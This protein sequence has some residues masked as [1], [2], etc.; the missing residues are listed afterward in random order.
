M[1]TTESNTALYNS[2]TNP[3][4]KI[5]IPASEDDSTIKLQL[6]TAL[7][8]FP[9]TMTVYRMITPEVTRE[10]VEELSDK[11]GIVGEI[12]NIEDISAKELW[13]REKDIDDDKI[14]EVFTATG[15]FVFNNDK[16][17]LKL[18]A[19]LPSEDEAAEI[20]LKFLEERGWLYPDTQ[21]KAT[22]ESTGHILVSLERTI[23]GMSFTGNGNK[24]Q[25]RVGDGGE[26]VQV[27]IN[28]VNEVEFKAYEEVGIKS[29]D[30]A[31]NEL[32]AGKKY[33]K[34]Y[35]AKTIII[36][37][38]ATAYWLNA[39]N[40]SQDYVVPVYVFRGYYLDANGNQLEDSFKYWVEAVE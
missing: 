3:K 32:I 23:N 31:Y 38:V 25:V 26:V 5:N 24:Y 9:E 11:F 40:Q 2:N 35:D 29:V 33:T 36:D 27:M 8:E 18:D 13:T 1:Q 15:G 30:Q 17:L 19:V 4:Y 16:K 28:P 21:V 7:P 12:H 6:E 20:A 39:M 10:Y 34:P 14:L 37:D 22:I